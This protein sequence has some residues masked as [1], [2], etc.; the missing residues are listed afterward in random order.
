MSLLLLRSMM[1]SYCVNASF[2]AFNGEMLK[3]TRQ[4]GSVWPG[5]S[6]FP[7]WSP[8]A[9]RKNLNPDFTTTRPILEEA[10]KVQ[11][12]AAPSSSGRENTQSRRIAITGSR[13]AQSCDRA[14]R[15]SRG[16]ECR[17]NVMTASSTTPDD[18]VGT[19]DDDNY[20]AN[21]T[22]CFSANYKLLITHEQRRL[23]GQCCLGIND[24]TGD[25]LGISRINST[26]NYPCALSPIERK[27]KEA[28]FLP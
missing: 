20:L 26:R 18:N 5:K 9:R 7:A 3:L 14:S 17:D 6:S 22:S 10:R 24:E 2:P 21:R 25:V 4:R 28:R 11:R 13:L 8:V 27:K 12:S 16:C 19:A 1:L 15:I 23:N